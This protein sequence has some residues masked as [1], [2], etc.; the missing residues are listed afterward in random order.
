MHTTPHQ[1]L[2]FVINSAAGNTKTDWE[3]TIRQYFD[4][5][6]YTIVLLNL[7]NPCSREQVQ[8]EIK[9]HGPHRIIAVGGDG[10]LKL[11]TESVLNS[12]LPVGVL[13]AGS[14]N[15]MAKE[16][17]IP[18]DAEKALDII[19]QGQVK[20]IDL[21]R[22]NKELCIHLSDIGFNAFVVKTFETFNKR[23]MWSYM[24]AAFK[25]LIRHRHM[26]V[27]IAGEKQTV[28]REAAMVV[29]ANATKYGTGAV[30]NPN[31]KLDDGRF[32]IIVIKKIA[33][34][35][36]IKMMIT[37]KDFD[38]DKT[39]LFTTTGVEIKSKH[40]V[41]FQVDGEYLGKIY[42]LKAECLPGAVQVIVP[43][44]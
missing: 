10:T 16:L 13:P 33:F 2:L 39:E 20:K 40:H 12:G 44:V 34:S 3:K 1:K 30:I 19:T 21:I 35:E 5:K 14:A 41:H 4:N 7:P 22:I 38:P 29:I 6:P 43:E 15:G 18:V 9:K 25:V 23:G 28:K 42:S 8:E 17:G 11:V 32:E 36:I 37:H 31:G 27:I 24:K 26:E